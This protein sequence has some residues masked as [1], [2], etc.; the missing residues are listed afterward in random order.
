MRLRVVALSLICLLQACHASTGVLPTS[1]GEMGAVSAPVNTPT[2][3]IIPGRSETA[4]SESRYRLSVQSNRLLTL[5]YPDQTKFE[6][7]G[8]ELV[9]HSDNFFDIYVAAGVVALE[10]RTSSTG[11]W[12]EIAISTLKTFSNPQ[13][14]SV[15]PMDSSCDASVQFCGPCPDCYPRAALVKCQQYGLSLGETVPECTCITWGAGGVGRSLVVLAFPGR[16][17]TIPQAAFLVRTKR[18]LTTGTSPI[19]A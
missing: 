7:R 9:A 6:R 3:V 17:T 8:S 11:P 19:T 15:L 4:S 13:Q 14:R 1:R 10:T 18:L 16:V 2:N 5:Y 12:T